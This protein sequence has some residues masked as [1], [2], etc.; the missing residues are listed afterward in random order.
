[1]SGTYV[2]FYTWASDYAKL[3][4][5]RTF[6]SDADIAEIRR[7]LEAFGTIDP[8]GGFGIFAF[9]SASTSFKISSAIISMRRLKPRQKFSSFGTN[10][11]SRVIPAGTCFCFAGPLEFESFR[12]FLKASFL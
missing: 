12:G 5:R 8:A 9:N 1:M 2:V 10:L 3:D 7:L 4:D 11:S 6:K